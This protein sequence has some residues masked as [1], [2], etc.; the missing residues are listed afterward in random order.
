MS[1]ERKKILDKAKKLK[2]LA[3]RGVGGEKENAKTMLDSFMS[4]HDIK[5]NEIISHNY[6]GS[7]YKYMSDEQFLK[8]MAT[9]FLLIGIGYIFSKLIKQETVFTNGQAF[10]VF[11]KKYIEAV[12]E[13]IK[14]N[15]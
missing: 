13:R 14:K 15:V 8:E 4:K 11:Q 1:E 2:E 7:K 5:L 9:E 10:N 12:D 6:K 3:D